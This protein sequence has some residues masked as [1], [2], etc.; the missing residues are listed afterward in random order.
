[1]ATISADTETYRELSVDERRE[2]L[3]ELEL[4]PEEDEE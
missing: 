2:Y 1:M 3:E 4:L